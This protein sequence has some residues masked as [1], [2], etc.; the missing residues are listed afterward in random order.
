[1]NKN[2][3]F[4]CYNKIYFDC[5]CLTG[6]N[7]RSKNPKSDSVIFLSSRS[8]FLSFFCG[9]LYEARKTIFYDVCVSRSLFAYPCALIANRIYIEPMSTLEVEQYSIALT[10]TLFFLSLTHTHTH[11]H[12]H[13]TVLHLTDTHSHTI[14]LVV[15]HAHTHTHTH[16]HF[17]SLF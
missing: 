4:I 5:R 10:L 14:S 13:C 11:T 15:K 6:Q 8:F 9:F 2:I 17:L 1:M 7:C 16:T 3:I 12:T